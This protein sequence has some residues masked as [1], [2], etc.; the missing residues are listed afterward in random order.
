MKL[1]EIN[2]PNSDWDNKSEAQQLA[3]VRQSGI[4]IIKIKNPS[5]NVQLAAIENNVRAIFYIKHPTEE[6]QILAASK[7]GDS[8]KYLYKIGIIPSQAVQIA[9]VTKNPFSIEYIPNPS[10]SVIKIVL[11]S[12]MVLRRPLIYDK[13]VHQLFKDNALLVKKWLR[14][15]ETMRNQI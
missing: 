4:N 5:N 14:Y 12:E 11:T 13:L 6:A 10:T 9:A 15:G 3:L 7:Y 2:T 8:I 1:H